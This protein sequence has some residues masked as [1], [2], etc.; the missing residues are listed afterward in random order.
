MRSSATPKTPLLGLDVSLQRDARL[1]PC[2]A[3][4]EGTPTAASFIWSPTLL[5]AGRSASRAI[6]HMGTRQR[7]AHHEQLLRRVLGEDDNDP[8]QEFPVCQ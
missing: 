3:W 6:H 7:P 1:P 8:I 2:S 4:R 5:E